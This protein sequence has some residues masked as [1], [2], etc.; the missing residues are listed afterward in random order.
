MAEYMTLPVDNLFVVPDNVSIPAAAFAEPLAAAFRIVEQVQDCQ[1]SWK[2]AVVGDGKLGLL[3]TEVLR[4]MPHQ[5]LVLFGRH[6]NKM[7]LVGD[8]VAKVVVGDESNLEEYDSKF[9]LVVEATGSPTGLILAGK[10]TKPLG[11]VILKTTCAAGNSDLNTAPFVVKE[12][13]IQGS[14]CGNFDMALGALA[15]KSIDVEKFITQSFPFDKAPEAFKEAAK[16]GIMKVQL[17]IGD[18]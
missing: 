6:A 10:L 12:I 18:E 14:R 5:S 11:K 3:I 15:S 13:T 16:R 4:T 8:D 17:V 2:L 7:A 9:D 1:P